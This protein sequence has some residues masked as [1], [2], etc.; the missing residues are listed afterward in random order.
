MNQS[1][2]I[3][4]NVLFNVIVKKKSSSF[5]TFA[6]VLLLIHGLPIPFL[7]LPTEFFFENKD[8]NMFGKMFRV[9]CSDCFI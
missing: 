2:Q 8:S 4:V 1:E 5:F 6:N 7:F 9:R 3:Q